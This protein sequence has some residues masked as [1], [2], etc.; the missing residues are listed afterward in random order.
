MFRDDTV[1]VV[2]KCVNGEVHL[3][4][5]NITSIGVIKARLVVQKVSEFI[6]I[7]YEEN[8]VIIKIV[9]GKI[10]FKGSNDFPSYTMINKIINIQN[11][12]KL[13][14]KRINIKENSAIR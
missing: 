3:E 5:E 6:D 10:D 9:N 13:K 8:P 4:V 12:Y 1:E 7:D 11:P 2:G 14:V